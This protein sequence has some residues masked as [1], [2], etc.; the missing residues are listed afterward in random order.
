MQEQQNSLWQKVAGFVS[1]LDY[2]FLS[3]SICGGRLYP[4]SY[5]VHGLSL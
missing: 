2:R 1:H 5:L 3:Y 4:S